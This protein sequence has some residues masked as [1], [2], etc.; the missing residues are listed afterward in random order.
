MTDPARK[1]RLN[2]F[3]FANLDFALLVRKKMKQALE[4]YDTNNSL[5]FE[6]DEIAAALI[7]ILNESPEEIHYV[8][9][10]V[11]RYDKDGDGTITYI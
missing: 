1:M 8:I 4:Q 2:K 10:N 3:T 7:G 11:F 5:T 9:K 6:E